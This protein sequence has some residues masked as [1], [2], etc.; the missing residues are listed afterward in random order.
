MK[1]TEPFLS[2]DGVQDTVPQKMALWHTGYLKLK[3]FVKKMAK[4]GRSL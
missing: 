2:R 4:A 1:R 3:E